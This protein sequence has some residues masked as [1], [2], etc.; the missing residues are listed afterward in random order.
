[1]RL[2]KALAALTLSGVLV[3]GGTA[4]AHA[5]TASP[6]PSASSSASSSS[7]GHSSTNCPNANG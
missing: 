2:R 7:S 1:M 3:G 4:I 5:A 6:S